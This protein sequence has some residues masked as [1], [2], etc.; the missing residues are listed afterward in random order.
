MPR[1]RADGT[2]AATMRRKLT[3]SYVRNLPKHDRARMIWDAQQPALAVLV[4]PS[5]HRAW[6]V[7]YRRNARPRWYTIGDATKINVK[8]ARRI[9]AKLVADVAEG[10]DPQAEKMAKRSAGTFKELR[11]RYVEQYAK[12]RNKSWRQADKLVRRH[13]ARW[14][15][16]Q[17][18]AITRADARSVFRA[19]EAPIVGNQVVASGSAIFSWAMREEIGGVVVNPFRGIEAN[20]TTERERILSDAELPKFWAAFA[21][22]DPV[23]AAALRVTLLSGQRPGEVA[24][25]RREHVKDGWWELPGAP[26]LKLRWPGTKNKMTHRVWL[27][28]AVRALMDLDGDGFVFANARGTSIGSLHEAM[29][30]ACEHVGISRS[31]KVTPHDLRRSCGSTIT[32][33]GFGRESMDRIL[34]HKTQG[35]GRVYDRHSY[36][37][38]DRRIMEAVAAHLLALASGKAAPSNVLPMAKTA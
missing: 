36:A 31:D 19:I 2:T 22:L 38:Q 9:A 8:D 29:A 30:R 15:H 5:G 13:L 7:I 11:E 20:P 35:I 17:A 18:G 1:T 32:G 14:D 37:E 28:A 10:K 4:Q 27:P 6:K 33:L 34:N 24:N 23:R 12:K 25:M 3:D 16:L 21:H 26:D